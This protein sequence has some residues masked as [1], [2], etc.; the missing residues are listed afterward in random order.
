MNSIDVFGVTSAG[1]GWATHSMEFAAA[2]N[3]VACVNF[4]TNRKK[5]LRQCLTSGPKAMFLRGMLRSPGAF[6]IVINGQSYPGQQAARWIVWETTRLPD[7]VRRQCDSTP[8]L[9]TPSTWGRDNLVANGIEPGRVAVV[10]EGVN[11][12]F[13]HP[14]RTA[15]AN[16]RF[17]FLFVG[18]WE[19]RKFVDQL[20]RAFADEFAGVD[21][22]ELVLHAHNPYMKTFSVREALQRLAIPAATPIIVSEPGSAE[23]LRGLYQSADVFVFPTRAE[24]WGL[25][26]LEAM[27][28]GVP[29]IVTRYS[30]PTDFVTNEG[31]YLLDVRGMVDARCELF[32]VQDGQW[33]EPD[34]DHLRF[35]MRHTYENREET[36]L[37]GVKAREEALAWSW[38][39]AATVALKTIKS[40][41]ALPY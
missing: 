1:T 38:A 13:F 19:S 39:N 30:A 41:L 14:A 21:D 40:T 8:Y 32:G 6:G 7:E 5:A 3:D 4:R 27:A 15:K 28:C 9:W 18:K 36:R 25:P 37:K 26:I 20:V 24:G 31:G 16:G 12:T 35:L 11:T 22:V 10:P 2:L 34:V 23:D 17:R 33:A 29:A